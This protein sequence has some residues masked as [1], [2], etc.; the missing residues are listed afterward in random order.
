MRKLNMKDVL[1]D[2]CDSEHAHCN[3]DCPVYK[4]NGSQVLDTVHDFDKNRGC[5]CFKNGAAML[6]FVEKKLGRKLTINDFWVETI[7]HLN[8]Q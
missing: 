5:D 3:D 2:V 8:I 7:Y 1:Y 6:K 4:L